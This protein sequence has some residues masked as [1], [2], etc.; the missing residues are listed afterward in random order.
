MQLSLPV[1]FE[2]LL[3]GLG[4]ASAVVWVGIIRRVLGRQPVIAHEPHS[5]VPW[6]GWDLVFL[7]GV[8]LA[9]E[10]AA[11]RGSIRDGEVPQE[12]SAAGVVVQSA[13]HLVWLAFA[14]AFMWAKV[15]ASPD[16]LGF[17]LTKLRGDLRL[18]GQMFLSVLLPVYG[19][20]LLLTQLM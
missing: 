10:S 7:V 16:D 8:A 17:D 1:A 5:M 6:S 15:G 14:I 19:L 12:I 3:W 18:A 2:S 4:V 20:Q 13:A 11:L 9:L